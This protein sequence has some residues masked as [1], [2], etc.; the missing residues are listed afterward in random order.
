MNTQK[1]SSV[2]DSASICKIIACHSVGIYLSMNRDAFTSVFLRTT[3]DD[4]DSAKKVES[5]G[6]VT[7]NGCRILFSKSS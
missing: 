5:T 1:N 3:V 4:F 2:L 7:K 6:I